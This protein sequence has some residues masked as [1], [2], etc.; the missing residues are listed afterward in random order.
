MNIFAKFRI[1]AVVFCQDLLFVWEP[2]DLAMS[3]HLDPVFQNE[4][5]KF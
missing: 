5:R 1:H 4:G 3:W 2:A